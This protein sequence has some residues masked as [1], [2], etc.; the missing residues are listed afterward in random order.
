MPGSGHRERGP[1]LL[2]VGLGRVG[3]VVPLPR[4]QPEPQ[5]VPLVPGNDVQVQVRGATVRDGY[6]RVGGRFQD[7]QPIVLK[8]GA[9][10]MPASTFAVVELSA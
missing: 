5:A 10:T 6:A 1:D 8:N 4:A 2:R 9:F 7:A 3:R